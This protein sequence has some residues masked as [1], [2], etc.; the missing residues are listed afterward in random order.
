[1]N[2]DSKKY[3]GKFFKMEDGSWVAVDEDAKHWSVF[4]TQ[5]Q[6]MRF[7]LH[8]KGWKSG[9][10][11]DRWDDEDDD[12]PPP[13]PQLSDDEISRLIAKQVLESIF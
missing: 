3:G 12:T 9:Y 5:E 4:K 6:A 8:S 7:L 1:M 2:W 10:Y 13:P 11:W